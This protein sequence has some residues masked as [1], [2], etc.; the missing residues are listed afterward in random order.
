MATVI[1]LPGALSIA[2][3]IADVI[4]DSLQAVNFKILEGSEVILQELY[5][6]DSNNKIV[7]RL[8]DFLPALICASVP[9]SDVFDQATA[10]K[11]YTFDID[12]VTTNHVVV[13]GGVNAN[14]DPALFLKGNWLTWQLQQKKVKYLDPEWLSYYAT[15]AV[16]VKV[17][18]YFK[19]G[20]P[21][22]INLANLAAGKLYSLNVNFQHI[23][24][25]FQGQPVYFDI[26]TESAT[27][28]RLSFIQRYVLMND[29]FDSE[30]LFVFANSLGGLDTIRFTGLKEEDNKY[31]IS[32]AQFDEDTED[33]NVEYDQVFKKNTGYFVS[34]RE[35]VWSSEFYNSRQRYLVTADGLK[36]I[37]VTSPVAKINSDDNT[38]IDYDFKFALA[39]QTKYLNFARA[40]SLPENVEIIDPDTEVFFLAP[41]LNEFPAANLN[42]LLLFPVQVPFTQEWR[43]LPYSAIKESFLLTLSGIGAFKGEWG[44]LEGN[45]EDQEDLTEA[46]GVKADLIDGKVPLTQLPDL[47]TGSIEGID[48]VNKGQPDVHIS[49][50]LPFRNGGLELQSKAF[51]DCWLANNLYFDGIDWRYRNAG[52]GNVIYFINGVVKIYTAAQ[53]IK[54]GIAVIYEQFSISSDGIVVKETVKGKSLKTTN[55]STEEDAYGNE[56]HKFNGVLKWYVTPAGYMRTASDNEPKASMVI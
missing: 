54:D 42:D 47:G 18:G 23:S 33:Y 55:W 16:S 30:D 49:C 19:V 44:K 26:W 38:S 52:V 56:L 45:I 12:G 34:D 32:S 37:T 43:H 17:K 36:K 41:R 40:E 9:T 11:T 29:Y 14:I 53:G 39:K 21:V 6:P 1:Q 10:Y 13:A 20:D 2:G 24:G 5:V 35:R 3:N 8:R 27:T 15:E 46:L 28:V 7:I 4:L 25:L 48:V 51:N 50:S 22:T 31:S